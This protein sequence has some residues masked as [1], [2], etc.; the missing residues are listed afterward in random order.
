MYLLTIHSESAGEIVQNSNPVTILMMDAPLHSQL[1]LRATC[2]T[3]L[4]ARSVVVSSNRTCLFGRAE[5]C[6]VILDSAATPGLTSRQHAQISFD[7]GVNSA[8]VL[9]DMK[10]TNGTF[11]ND[12]RIIEAVLRQGDRV[13]FGV[14]GGS[15]VS[16]GLPPVIVFT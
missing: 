3:S 1:V 5:T 6:D 9:R 7:R 10:S 11:H 2:A 8:F 13:I 15:K 4:N 12:T 14:K 16:I